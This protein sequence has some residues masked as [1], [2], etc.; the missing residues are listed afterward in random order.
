[1]YSTERERRDWILLPII[2]LLG[3]LFMYLAGQRAI[4]MA[5]SW[6]VVADMASNLDPNAQFQEAGVAGVIEPVRAEI[7]TPPVWAKTYLTPGA[8]NGGSGMA[9]PA[10]P[11][12][13]SPT[14]AGP[15]PT[16]VAPTATPVSASPTPTAVVTEPPAYVPPQ[17]T[18]TKKKKDKPP[19][20]TATTVPTAT[21]VPV[22]STLDPADEVP[23]PAAANTGLPDGNVTDKNNSPDGSYFV[24]DVSSNPVHVAATPDGNY[25]L[26]YYEDENPNDSGLIAMDQVK[27]GITNDSTGQTYYEVFNWG[28]GQPDTN[29]NLNTNTLP[30]NTPPDPAIDP[31]EPDNQVI[32]TDD[33]YKDPAAT[34]PPNPQTGVLIDVDQA[35]SHPP[36]GDYK[37][38]VIVAPPAPSS[39]D[40]GQMDSID[41]TEVPIPPTPP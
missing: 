37:Y 40:G 5:P 12:S 24:V 1:M 8:N 21:P 17:P 6:H 39:V 22:V 31:A 20:P 15:S 27:I 11:A 13:N 28:D 14:P 19:A 25:D 32:P 35:P 18:A 4:R 9:A 38:V 36:P 33:L 3:I 30:P 23:V 34:P 29:S 16:P 2:V 41:V 7:L 10:G 26:V